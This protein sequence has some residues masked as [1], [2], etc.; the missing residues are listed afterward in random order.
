LPSPA[1]FKFKKSFSSTAYPERSLESVEDVREKYWPWDT[2][3]GWCGA[4][5]S[6]RVVAVKQS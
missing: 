4:L 2:T 1:S 3:T 5:T 6:G